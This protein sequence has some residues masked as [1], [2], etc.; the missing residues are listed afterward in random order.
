MA[1][2]SA[3]CMYCFGPLPQGCQPHRKYCSHRCRRDMQNERR[4]DER[5]EMREVRDIEKYRPMNDPYSMQRNDL[6]DLTVE[7]IEAINY[8]LDAAPDMYEA[9]WEKVDQMMQ[10]VKSLPSEKKNKNWLYLTTWG[11]C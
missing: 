5:A 8:T 2:G 7:E 1:S 11:M 9:R 4:R 6:A 3:F 10:R